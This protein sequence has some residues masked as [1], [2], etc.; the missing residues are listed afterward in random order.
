LLQLN[1]KKI[2]KKKNEEKEGKSQ[3]ESQ[4]IK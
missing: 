4:N 2:I 3:K 1:F